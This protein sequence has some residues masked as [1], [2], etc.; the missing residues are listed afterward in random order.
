M[1]NC[2]NVS[3]WDVEK[4]WKQTWCLYNISHVI[5]AAECT[6]NNG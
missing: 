1:A 3:V 2:Y 6:L 4:V 5:D